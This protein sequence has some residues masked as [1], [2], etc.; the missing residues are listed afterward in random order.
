MY[1][2]LKGSSGGNYIPIVARLSREK[3]NDTVKRRR[4]V[5]VTRLNRAAELK[6]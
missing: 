2:I 4:I 6:V 5:N 1:Q 3:G